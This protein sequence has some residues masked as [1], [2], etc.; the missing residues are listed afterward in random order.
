MEYHYLQQASECRRHLQR[1][2]R[3]Y[4]VLKVNDAMGPMNDKYALAGVTI[5]KV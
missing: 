2:L 5:Q 3:L 1:K 4:R